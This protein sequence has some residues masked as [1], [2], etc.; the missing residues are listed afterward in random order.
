MS[1]EDKQSK[2]KRK[3]KTQNSQNRKGETEELPSIMTLFFFNFPSG[4]TAVAILIV[5]VT[6]SYMIDACICIDRDRYIM[7]TS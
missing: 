6:T 2:K 1:D 3:K 5:M 7:M 4:G